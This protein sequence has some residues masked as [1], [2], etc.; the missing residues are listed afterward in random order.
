[1]V[2]TAIR[3]EKRMLI[4]LKHLCFPGAWTLKHHHGKG[5]H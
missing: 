3:N 4:E 1:M 2:K 5:P